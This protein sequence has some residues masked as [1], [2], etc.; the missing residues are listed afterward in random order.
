MLNELL[1]K[2]LKHTI[3]EPRP[4]SRMHSYTE[5]GMPSNHSQFMSFFASYVLFFVLIRLPPFNQNAFLERFW[6]LLIIGG[7]W[8]ASLLV[9]Y[10][11]VYLQYHSWSQVL[12]GIC[13]G[14]ATGSLWFAL[15]QFCLSPLLFPKIVTWKISEL[16]L[17]RDT[18]LIPN[19]LWFEYTATRKEASARSRKLNSMKMQ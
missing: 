11:R 4:V 14:L 17:L 16:L 9:C 18:T 12:M 15:T 19:V 10:S 13:I 7:T 5:Y 2:I 3:R 1:N 8:F 6:R